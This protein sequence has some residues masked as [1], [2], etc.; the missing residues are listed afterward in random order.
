MAGK[1]V[2]SSGEMENFSDCN[3]LQPLEQ[4]NAV[5]SFVLAYCSI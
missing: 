2:A 4:S 1:L 5:F 3:V